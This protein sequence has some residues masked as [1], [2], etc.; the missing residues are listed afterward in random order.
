M[1]NNNNKVRWE[2]LKRKKTGHIN[3]VSSITWQWTQPR[4]LTAFGST[5]VCCYIPVLSPHINLSVPV[6][7]SPQ[8]VSPR[9]KWSLPVETPSRAITSMHSSGSWE[10]ALHP[11]EGECRSG[12]TDW[13]K[14]VVT[15]TT[16]QYCNVEL[17]LLFR[18]TSKDVS[19][20][21]WAWDGNYTWTRKA[22]DTKTVEWGRCCSLNLSFSMI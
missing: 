1:F 19:P 16:D 13:K 3:T 2:I 4:N 15:S 18:D 12:Q 17:H 8:W 14:R 6:A 20:D 22:E 11:P 9:T 21:W 10:P 5:F 7:T